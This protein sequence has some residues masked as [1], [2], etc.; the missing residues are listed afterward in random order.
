MQQFVTDQEKFWAEKFGDEYTDRNHGA[1]LLASNIAWFSKILNRTSDVSS[2][3]EIGANIGL[4]LQAIRSLVPGI[5]L[6]A[7]EINQHACQKLSQLGEIDIYNQS[8]LDFSCNKKYDFVLSKGVLIHINPDK[9]PQVYD[10]MYGASGRYV[11]IVEYYNPKPVSIDYRGHSNKL[12]K[13]DFAGEFLDRFKDVA[14]VDYGFAYHRDKYF[15]QDDITW[16][17]LEKISK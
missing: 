3:L 6:A 2:V 9:L 17:L 13:R 15:A 11:C 8:I 14:L 7:I 1:T 4:N 10:L 5:K 16:F 12:F